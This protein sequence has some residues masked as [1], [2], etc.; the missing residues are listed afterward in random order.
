MF[1]IKYEDDRGARKL[2]VPHSN[3]EASKTEKIF[4]KGI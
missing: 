2:R 3:L 4:K 1:N